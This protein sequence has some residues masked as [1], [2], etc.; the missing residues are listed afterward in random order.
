ATK[1]W[2]CERLRRDLQLRTLRAGGA[3][4]AALGDDAGRGQRAAAPDAWVE[5]G[6]A[7]PDHAADAGWPAD[8]PW[9]DRRGGVRHQAAGPPGPLAAGAAG[10]R[11]LLRG[12]SVRR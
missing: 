7:I 10:L 11:R 4:A 9:P 8:A 2:L 3:D 1:A 12:A 5:R 6:G